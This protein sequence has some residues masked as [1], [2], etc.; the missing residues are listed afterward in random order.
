M[1]AYKDR[2]AV[3]PPEYN[4]LVDSGNIIFHQP[5][6]IDGRVVG[7]WTRKLKK[8]SVVITTNLLRPLTTA[9]MDALAAAAKRFGAYLGLSATLEYRRFVCL[10]AITT[11]TATLQS[12]CPKTVTG[13]MGSAKGEQLMKNPVEGTDIRRMLE[14]IA[15]LIGA[16]N[17]IVVSVAFWQGDF[18]FPALYL[19]QIALL[20][21]LVTVFVA[22][23]RRLSTRWNAFPWLVAGILLAFVILGG[24]SIGPFLIPAFLAF[25]IV[26]L[27]LRCANPWVN[28]QARR[29]IFVAAVAQGA[30]MVLMLSISSNF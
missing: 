7:T 4:A 6:L 5:I 1:V 24:Y 29:P 12:G 11:T 18:P 25:T 28:K 22:E 17:C 30:L 27:L 13:E 26:G 8:G 21:L 19:I 3:S 9:K 10:P 16:A 15:V 23:R 20:G 14:W 2:D